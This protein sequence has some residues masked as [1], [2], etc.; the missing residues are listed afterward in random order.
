MSRYVASAAFALAVAACDFGRG[1]GPVLAVSAQVRRDTDLRQS[2][3]TDR[4]HTAW[5]ARFEARL[6][7]AWHAP[8]RDAVPAPLRITKP[9]PHAPCHVAE[10]CM[11]ETSEALIAWERLRVPEVER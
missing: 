6:L 10:L 7:F 2:L 1:F 4:N 9:L 3:S 5:D 11:R 8:I